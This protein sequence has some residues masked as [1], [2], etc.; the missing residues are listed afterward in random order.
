MSPCN[1]IRQVIWK[2]LQIFLP[3][4]IHQSR[5]VVLSHI[6]DGLSKFSQ[7]LLSLLL[8]HLNIDYLKDTELSAIDVDNETLLKSNTTNLL[9]SFTSQAKKR[10]EE[11]LEMKITS[12][13]QGI[14]AVDRNTLGYSA[15]HVELTSA[16]G[17]SLWICRKSS[18]LDAYHK[19][20]DV[21]VGMKVRRGKDFPLE[22]DSDDCSGTL[23]GEVKTI[24]KNRDGGKLVTVE[25]GMPSGRDLDANDLNYL[26]NLHTDHKKIQRNYKYGVPV[27]VEGKVDSSNPSVTSSV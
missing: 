7:D 25:W 17:F 3:S 18:W 5:N 15:R 1:P 8:Q 14:I 27:K 23:V 22:K 2:I 20:H 21:E 19:N 16:F 26:E 13:V 24:T 6:S 4:A 11:D 10:K 12:L 9:E